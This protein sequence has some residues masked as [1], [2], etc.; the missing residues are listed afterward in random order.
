M[1]MSI[2]YQ[3]GYN[4]TP[5]EIIDMHKGVPGHEDQ[6]SSSRNFDVRHHHSLLI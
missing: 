5:P 3:A 1:L 6:D 4:N 2:A